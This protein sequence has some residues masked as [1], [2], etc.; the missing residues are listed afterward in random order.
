MLE[1]VQALQQVHG[2]GTS[3]VTYYIPQGMSP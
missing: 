3:L 1:D 2:S